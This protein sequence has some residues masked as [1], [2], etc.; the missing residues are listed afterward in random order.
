[1]EQDANLTE[2]AKA[3]IAEKRAELLAG[4]DTEAHAAF[5][6]LRSK[7]QK[8]LDAAGVPETSVPRDTVASVIGRLR[9]LALEM[10]EFKIAERLAGLKIEKTSSG[11]ALARFPDC[12]GHKCTIGDSELTADRFIWLGPENTS[13]DGSETRM[14]LTQDRVAA[15]LPALHRFVKT[16]SIA[17]A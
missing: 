14:L 1:M 10:T 11:Y 2:E 9:R 17:E 8:L 6:N 3:Q 15:L 5:I 13:G 16:G 4:H 12:Y 7:V